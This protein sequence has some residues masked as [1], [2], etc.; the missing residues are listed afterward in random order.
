MR[1]SPTTHFLLCQS[2]TPLCPFDSPEKASA[3]LP[4]C[5]VCSSFL[6]PAS[7]VFQ[8]PLSR[9][10]SHD[11]TN[12]FSAHRSAPSFLHKWSSSDDIR[13]PTPRKPGSPIFLPPQLHDY[14]HRQQ[15]PEDELTT[16]RQF[17]EGGLVPR[18]SSACFFRDEIT[19]FIDE[20]P[21]P[22]PACSPRHSRLPLA[23]R[24]DRRLSLGSREEENTDRPRRCSLACSEALQLQDGEQA[25]CERTLEASE[26]QTF[27]DPK[28]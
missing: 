10:M 21:Q 12:I 16:L 23:S 13:I 11:E 28:L 8:V 25:L 15:P 9:R 18:G 7:S 14:Q 3:T 22:S 4:S 2:P 26:P 17:L 1:G 5:S 6:S 27:Q 24:R 20:T 19:T